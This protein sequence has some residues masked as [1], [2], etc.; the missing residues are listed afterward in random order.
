MTEVWKDVEGYEGLYKISN[1]GEVWSTRKQ[2]LLKKGEITSGYYNVVLTKNKKRKTFYIH[3]LVANNF[4][5]N[6][7]EKP[8]VNHIDENKTN[9]HCSN[10]EWCT[11]EENMNWGTAIERIK[12]TRK[13]S[14]KWKEA[15][16]RRTT[17]LSKPIIGLNI[18]DG[19]T[20]EFPSINEAGRN[21]YHQSNIWSCLNGKC[22]KHKGYKWFYKKD[23]IQGVGRC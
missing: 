1:Y 3:R 23:Y 19:K 22:S 14:S 18:N 8:C 4:I 6:T 13:Y 9:N 11:Y 20:I 15:H 17:K 2:G 12:K 21:G 10:L 16:E 7:L 5:D